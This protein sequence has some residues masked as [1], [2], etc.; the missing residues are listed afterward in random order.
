MLQRQI[1]VVLD[2]TKVDKAPASMWVFCINTV[3]FCGSKLKYIRCYFS[4]QLNKKK[5]VQMD[6]FFLGREKRILLEL[7]EYIVQD[8]DHS[9]R[10]LSNLKYSAAIKSQER[11][12][13]VVY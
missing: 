9:R 8:G 7:F 6:G 2:T 1:A 5:T 10:L 4:L 13:R 12:E 11:M 3:Y